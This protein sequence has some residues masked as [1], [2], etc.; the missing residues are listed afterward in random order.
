MNYIKRF[1]LNTDMRNTARLITLKQACESESS[2][3]FA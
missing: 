1:E 2:S 3:L